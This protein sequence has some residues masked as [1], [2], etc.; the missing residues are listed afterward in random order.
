MKIPRPLLLV[1]ALCA[2]APTPRRPALELSSAA[3]AWSISRGLLAPESAHYDPKTGAVYVS[4]VVGSPF[5]KDGR[6]FI[7]KV[8]PKGEILSSSWVGG[9]NAPKGIRVLG[10]TLYVSDVD[11]LLEISIPQAAVRYR[12]KIPGARFLNDVA[13]APDGTVYVSDMMTNRIHRVSPARMSEVFLQGPSLAGPNGLY[14]EGRKLYVACWGPISDEATLKTSAAGRLL[15]VDVATKK[16][17][18]V[19]GP[20]GNLDGLEPDGAGGWFVSDWVAGKLWRVGRSGKAELLLSGMKG[21]ADLGLSARE[22]LLFMPQM[23]ADRLE[24]Y[25]LGHAVR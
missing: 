23:G 11:E 18:T 15:S 9:L 4:N 1:A 24:A 22:R 13:A 10:D 21:A 17:K 8:S 19:S 7:A 6:G 14:L 16:V 3:P 25:P 20:L 2:C 5:E 12:I